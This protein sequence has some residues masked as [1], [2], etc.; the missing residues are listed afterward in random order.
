M[1]KNSRALF[2][3]IFAVVIFV[4]AV[5]LILYLKS[6]P[7]IQQIGN[8]KYNTMKCVC[9]DNSYNQSL[10][11]FED[12]S[13]TY[14]MTAQTNIGGPSIKCINTDNSKMCEKECNED[15]NCVA[16]TVDTHNKQCC[17]KRTTEPKQNVWNY[18][19]YEKIKNQS[20]AQQEFNYDKT[21]GSY[22]GGPDIK[23]IQTQN[24]ELCKKECDQNPNC[25]AYN[26]DTHNKVCCLKTIT[27]N[28]QN[29]WNMSLYRKG[30]PIE[31]KAVF[32][33]TYERKEQKYI[34]GTD[35]KCMPAPDSAAC[36]KECD[37]NAMCVAYNDDRHNKVCCLKSSTNPINTAWN[38]NYYEKI[39]RGTI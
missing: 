36:K 10:E 37:S 6:S 16:Y 21:Q 17:L 23:C 25:I 19:M 24:S 33:G 26:E 12:A 7:D 14:K 20:G 39:G 18:N 8:G 29:A 38:M 28:V 1:N 34:G 35:I 11:N 31:K 13:I 3:V 5:N 27:G 32:T 22:I 4:L 30:K 15:A 2:I 9:T